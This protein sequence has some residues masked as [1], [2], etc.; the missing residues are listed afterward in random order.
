[1]LKEE[2]KIIDLLSEPLRIEG[3]ELVEVKIGMVNAQKTIQLYID[4]PNGIQIDDCVNANK[5]TKNIFIKTN[6]TYKNYLLEVSSPGI[7]RKLKKPD[8]FKSSTGKRIKVH[9]Q[10]KI[11]GSMTVTGDLQKCDEETIC[12]IPDKN[13]SDMVIPYSLISRANLEPLLEF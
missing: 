11:R 13:G 5:V 1:M 8:H 9:L 2:Q 6:Q 7:F 3:F 4:S 10:K 12:V